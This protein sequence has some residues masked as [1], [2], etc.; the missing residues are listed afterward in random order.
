MKTT[1]K[2]LAYIVGALVSLGLINAHAAEPIAT[3]SRIRTFVFNDNEVFPL[4]VHFGYQSYIEFANN[5]QIEA[6]S[7]GD[8][9]PW[10]ITPVKNRLF[11]KPIDAYSHTNMTVIT[12]KHTYQFDL[13]SKLPP[14]AP[15]ADLTYVARFYYPDNSFDRVT[16]ANGTA[17]APTTTETPMSTQK[18]Y[19]YNYTM[20]GSDAIAPLKVFD[21]GNVTYFQF[22]NNNAVVP[23]LALKDPSGETTLPTRKYGSYVAV[24]RIASQFTLRVGPDTVEIFNE[25]AY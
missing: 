25:N 2:A 16:L 14:N 12:N 9:F 21:D 22:S 15:D 19:N 8:A 18:S 24:D 23:S 13:E 10:Q 5:E 3:D 17:V 6:I 7:L 11:V 20:V 4:T 1:H